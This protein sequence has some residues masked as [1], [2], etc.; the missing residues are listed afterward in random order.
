VE[1][2]ITSRDQLQ[3]LEVEK[4][5]K[6]YMLAKELGMIYKFK[7]TIISVTSNHKKYQKQLVVELISNLWF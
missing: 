2:G 4:M 5:R 7:T 3:T 6:Y 1:V